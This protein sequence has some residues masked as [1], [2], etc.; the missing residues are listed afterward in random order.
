MALVLTPE[1]TLSANALVN[2]GALAFSVSVLGRLWNE[3]LSVLSSKVSELRSR[4]ECG[5]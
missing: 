3:A 4:Q 2:W 5:C 1:V